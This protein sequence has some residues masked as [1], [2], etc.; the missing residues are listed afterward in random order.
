MKNKS[1]LNQWVADVSEG[2]LIDLHRVEVGIEAD[3]TVISEACILRYEFLP[4]MF[5]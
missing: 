5:S 1:L 2:G 3:A 4:V